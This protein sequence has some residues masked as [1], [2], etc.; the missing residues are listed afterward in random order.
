MVLQRFK[1]FEFYYSLSLFIHKF[2]VLIFCLSPEWVY[3]KDS[4]LHLG[5]ELAFTT[6]RTFRFSPKTHSSLPPLYFPPNF[7]LPF[8]FFFYF[9]KF[10]HSNNILSSVYSSLFSDYYL[11]IF[12]YFHII[13]CVPPH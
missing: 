9:C 10:K 8:S 12:S 3:L 13:I 6:L 2:F 11:L 1:I 4:L 5:A 7:L